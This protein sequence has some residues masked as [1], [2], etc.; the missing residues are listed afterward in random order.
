MKR[1]THLEADRVTAGAAGA[2]PETV[3][4]AAE[5]ITKVAVLKFI[6]L[7]VRMIIVIVGEKIIIILS[8]SK[9]M[10]FVER[11]LKVRF[12]T[13]IQVDGGNRAVFAAENEGRIRRSDF[14]DA[15]V[16]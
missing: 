5:K 14:L 10:L 2:N 7:D 6:L 13:K 8:I 1:A 3:D 9:K 16:F 12:H 4:K 15:Y 11:E